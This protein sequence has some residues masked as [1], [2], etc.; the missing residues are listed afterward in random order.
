M[1]IGNTFHFKYAIFFTKLFN[2]YHLSLAFCVLLAVSFICTRQ[3]FI[4]NLRDISLW[5]GKWNS[6]TKIRIGVTR[7]CREWSTDLSKISYQHLCVICS[8]KCLFL[9]HLT[10]FAVKIRIYVYLRRYNRMRD[11]KY[12]LYFIVPRCPKSPFCRYLCVSECTCS[13]ILQ[14][15]V[16]CFWISLSVDVDIAPKSHF[17]L[18]HLTWIPCFLIAFL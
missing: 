11:W 9:S 18:C 1:R 10:R 4:E 5:F 7:T 14:V 6:L 16:L 12:F 17:S 13:S 15:F 8:D 3:Q 2:L